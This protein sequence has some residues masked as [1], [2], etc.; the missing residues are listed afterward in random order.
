MFLSFR[1][2]LLDLDDFTKKTH[3]ACEYIKTVHNPLNRPIFEAP[4]R[5]QL[6]LKICNEFC[7]LFEVRKLEVHH[8]VYYAFRQTESSDCI[9]TI[10]NRNK[11]GPWPL[12]F[13]MT[14]VVS[15]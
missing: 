9:H 6:S 3:K 8:L 4:R 10:R 14:Y 2:Y 11:Y 12:W 1:F 15:F 7:L 13:A 5:M